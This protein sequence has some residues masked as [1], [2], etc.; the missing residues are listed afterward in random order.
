MAEVINRHI[1]LLESSLSISSLRR[2]Q[3]FANHERELDTGLSQDPIDTP[4]GS[5]WAYL[6]R[7]EELAT[8][9]AT[10]G[11]GA[12]GLTSVEGHAWLLGPVLTDHLA[13]PDNLLRA[14]SLME[15]EPGQLGVSAHVLGVGRKTNSPAPT[16]PQKPAI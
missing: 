13:E 14:L 12:V 2:T 3:V 11:F 4:D 7:P 15:S 10:A 5:F 1:T 16:R 6:H 9:L 8:E